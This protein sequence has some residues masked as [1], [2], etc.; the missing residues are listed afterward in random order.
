MTTATA[1]LPIVRV[2]RPRVLTYLGR[3]AEVTVTHHD[4]KR[5][6]IRTIV[7]RYIDDADPRNGRWLAGDTTTRTVEGDGRTAAFRVLEAEHL[8]A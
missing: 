1:P 7:T 8:F 4:R 3:R 2:E 6:G 5:D